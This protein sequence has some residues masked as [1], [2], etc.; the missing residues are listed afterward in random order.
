MFVSLTEDSVLRQRAVA[1]GVRSLIGGDVV[2][3]D[4]DPLIHVLVV[5]DVV[6]MAVK[7]IRR[8][9]HFSFHTPLDTSPNH[10]NISFSLLPECASLH[11]LSAEAYVDPVF[12]QRTEGH[13][14]PESPVA[15]SLAHHVCT[16]L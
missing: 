12:Q 6:S 1:D 8:K 4:A 7:Q 14:L 3:R 16:A 13:V 11:V 15:H 2:H 9:H 10:S 5:K